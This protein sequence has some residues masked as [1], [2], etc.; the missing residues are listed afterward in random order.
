MGYQMARPID[1]LFA[2]A[3]AWTE[4]ARELLAS[5]EPWDFGKFGSPKGPPR[6]IVQLET[7]AF[8]ATVASRALEH[9]EVVKGSIARD[10]AQGEGE[11]F[12]ISLNALDP[13]VRDKMLK[14]T[15][16]MVQREMEVLIEYGLFELRPNKHYRL[17]K[18]GT[19]IYTRLGEEK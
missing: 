17:T 1:G 2:F 13:K 7:G 4:I 16:I 10:W 9:G 14:R 8:F 3:R 6:S 19:E 18:Y 5:Q 12:G 15:A 11:P